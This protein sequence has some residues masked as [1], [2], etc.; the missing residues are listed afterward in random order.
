MAQKVQ[1]TLVDDIDGGE[2]A[3]TVP[4]SLDG[5]SYEIDLS[6]ENAQKMREALALY[7][8]NA[9]RAGTRTGGS[10]SRGG[11]R[12]SSRPATPGRDTGEIRSWA[13]ENGHVVNDRGRIPSA[14]IEAYEKAHA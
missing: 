9:R 8:G 7:V 3:E 13:R 10:A 2:A 12:R 14:V 5:V 1:V 4:F 6:E 11:A